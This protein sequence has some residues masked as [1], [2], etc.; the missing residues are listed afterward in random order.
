[1]PA[2]RGHNDVCHTY[3]VYN[4]IEFKRRINAMQYDAMRR[5]EKKKKPIYLRSHRIDTLLQA[6]RNQMH[7]NTDISIFIAANPQKL[8]YFLH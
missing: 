5:K 4:L 7:G 3:D 1:M 2:H 8:P 6:L